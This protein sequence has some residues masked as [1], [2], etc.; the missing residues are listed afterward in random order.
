MKALPILLILPLLSSCAFSPVTKPIDETKEATK[1]TRQYSI[2]PEE[3]FSVSRKSLKLVGY[4]E[5]MALAEE[6]VIKTEPSL[7]KV[8]D[9]YDCGTW[10]GRVITGS[11]DSTALVN[12]SESVNGS[13]ISMETTCVTSFTG[14]NL[15]GMTTRKETFDCKSNGKLEE[16]FFRNV[17]TLLE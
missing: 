14:K 1:I 3:A 16:L 4:K 13:N 6:G 17:D 12:I 9:Q 5:S 8:T 2:S 15:W 7:G 11:C 10:N